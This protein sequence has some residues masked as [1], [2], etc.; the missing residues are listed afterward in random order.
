MRNSFSFPKTSSGRL[1]DTTRCLPS[2]LR[3]E[4]SGTSRIARA[5]DTE[6]KRHP[7]AEQL[8]AL[9]DQIQRCDR[10]LVQLHKSGRKDRARR[11]ETIRTDA[12]AKAQLV[13]D[14]LA[15]GKTY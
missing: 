9:R 2:H 6:P 1:S 4:R 11:V 10:Q 15:K 8:G 13:A 12:I 5:M 7:L 14:Q 3:N